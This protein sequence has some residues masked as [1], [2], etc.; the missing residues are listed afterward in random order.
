MARYKSLK[1]QNDLFIFLEKLIAITNTMLVE[2]FSNFQSPFCRSGKIIWPLC[3]D[4]KDWQ[5]QGEDE[6]QYSSMKRKLEEDD[7]YLVMASPSQRLAT[8][9]SNGI[10]PGFRTSENIFI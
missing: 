3:I 5:K 8:S 6:T 1:A 2:S 9:L 4:Y 10:S 7:D